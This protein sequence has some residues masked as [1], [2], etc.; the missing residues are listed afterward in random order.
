MNRRPEKTFSQEIHTDGQQVHEKILKVTYRQRNA[1]QNYSE[2]LLHTEWSS[3]RSQITN[4]ATLKK[5]EHWYSAGGNVNWCSHYGKQY[6]DSS[7]NDT[8]IQQFHSF[9][10]ISK[11]NENSNLKRYMH[12][13]V[14]SNL[15]LQQ[16]SYGSNLSVHQHMNGRKKFKNEILFRLTGKDSDA[17][18]D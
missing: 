5:R 17:G 16:A 2:L 15:I 7:R 18:K 4:V 1:N 3:K 12:P 8:M 10:C 9:G 13:N 6:G 11:E 14:H